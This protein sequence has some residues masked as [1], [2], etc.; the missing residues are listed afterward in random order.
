MLNSCQS[1]TSQWYMLTWS[2]SCNINITFVN[3]EDNMH[4]VLSVC[5]VSCSV[6]TQ[7]QNI[8]YMHIY[9]AS[10]FR[11]YIYCIWSSKC[12]NLQ[13]NCAVL[14]EISN[15]SRPTV[16]RNDLIMHLHTTQ[17]IGMGSRTADE[18]YIAHK[19]VL[20]MTT[21]CV[22]NCSRLSY[23]TYRVKYT[24]SKSFSEVWYS[25]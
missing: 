12:C 7:E 10:W 24:S 17:G 22:T 4:A 20:R 9:V 5:W 15:V 1:S 6:G 16:A 25:F 2:M 18:Q 23:H 21:V 14:R 8:I 19:Y 11:Q 13:R 3:L